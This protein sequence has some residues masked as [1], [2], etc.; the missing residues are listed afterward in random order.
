VSN[1][2]AVPLPVPPICKQQSYA[3]YANI[4]GKIKKRMM[5]MHKKLDRIFSVLLHQAFT[6]NLTAGWREVH[7]RE[8]LREMEVQARALEMTPAERTAQIDTI[9]VPGSRQTPT[10]GRP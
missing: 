6:G 10:R 5:A 1:V 9:I 4:V 7:M 3:S 8:L 2:K